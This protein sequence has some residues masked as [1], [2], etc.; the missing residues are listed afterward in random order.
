MK[1]IVRNTFIHPPFCPYFLF[2][3]KGLLNV[4]VWPIKKIQF[5]F[6]PTRHKHAVVYNLPNLSLKVH[7]TI[8]SLKKTNKNLS[9]F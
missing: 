9:S 4:S 8:A 2:L 5:A 7:F 1:K 3:I 6:L